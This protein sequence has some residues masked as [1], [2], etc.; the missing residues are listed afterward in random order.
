VPLQLRHGY[1]ADLPR[2][3]LTGGHNPVTELSIEWTHTADQP[4]SARFGVGVSHLRG[5]DAGSSRTPFHLACRA[6]TV[7]QC[8]PSRRCQGCSRLFPR[9]RD[10]TALSFARLLRQP[11]GGA[12]SSPLGINSASWR[13][14]PSSQTMTQLAG[15]WDAGPGALPLERPLAGVARQDVF[16]RTSRAGGAHAPGTANKRIVRRAIA[17]CTVRP[18]HRDHRNPTECQSASPV[19]HLPVTNF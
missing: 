7:W 2:G 1:A 18:R 8:R 5:F 11:N 14:R 6:S 16:P 9:F 4:I 15:Q 13:T 12:L 10:R 17:C 19:T 3:L